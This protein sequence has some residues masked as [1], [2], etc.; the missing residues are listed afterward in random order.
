[1]EEIKKTIQKG[2]IEQILFCG[3][4]CEI[5][6]LS[7]GCIITLFDESFNQL[8][9]IDINA[10]GFAIHNDNIYIIDDI[11]HCIYLLDNN[12]NVKKKHLDRNIQAWIN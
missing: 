6:R 12:L 9:Q 10:F 7:N 5:R 2:F 4:P 8:K 3:D 11:T 1:M